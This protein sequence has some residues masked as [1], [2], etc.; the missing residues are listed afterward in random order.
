MNRVVGV[1][2]AAV[3]ATGA[4]LSL[5][6]CGTNSTAQSAPATSTSQQAANAVV[7]DVRTP[8]EYSNGHLEG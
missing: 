4:L 3:L 2:A 7:L 8:A 1:A 6:A 5:T